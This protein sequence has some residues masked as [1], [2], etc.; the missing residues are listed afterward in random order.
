MKHHRLTFL[1]GIVATWL[2]VIAV[3]SYAANRY[4]PLM[5]DLCWDRSPGGDGEKSDHREKQHETD[6][7]ETPFVSQAVLEDRHC[8]IFMSSTEHHSRLLL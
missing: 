1:F 4:H 8:L 3:E 5:V 7:R 6:H 2:A